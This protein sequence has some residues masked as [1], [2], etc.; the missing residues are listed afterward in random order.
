ST[1]TI[2]ADNAKFYSVWFVL[3]LGGFL[4]KR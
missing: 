2:G 1:S 4:C 3:E